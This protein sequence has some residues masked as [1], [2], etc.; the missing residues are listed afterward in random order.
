MLIKLLSGLAFCLH[1]QLFP[2]HPEPELLF[3]NCWHSLIFVLQLALKLK[4]NIISARIAT[5][6][7]ANANENAKSREYSL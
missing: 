6:Q 5:W 3:N 1:L 2:S 4:L 7:L